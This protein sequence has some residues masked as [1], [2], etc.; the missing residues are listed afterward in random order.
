MQMTGPN[1]I[2]ENDQDPVVWSS[3]IN[4]LP[5]GSSSAINSKINTTIDH[6]FSQSPFLAK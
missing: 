4:G 3:V 1:N 5:E 6:A 2:S